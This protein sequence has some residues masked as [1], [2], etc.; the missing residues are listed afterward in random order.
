VGFASYK[1]RVTTLPAEVLAAYPGLSVEPGPYGTGLINVTR[2]GRLGDADVVVQRVHP[3]FAGTVHDDIEAV[4]AHVASKG[5]ATPRLVRAK[6]GALFAADAEGRPWRVLT[7]VDGTS[8]DRVSGPDHATRAGELLGRFHAAVDDLDHAYVHVRPGVHDLGY[9]LEGLT[10]ALSEHGSHRLYDRA[11]ELAEAIIA[12]QGELAPLDVSRHRH[13]HGD[14]KVSN[15]LF[16]RDGKGV[17]LVDLDTLARMPWPF[18]IG[19]ALRSWCNPHGEDREEPQVDEGIFEAA[20]RGFAR[21]T[22]GGLSLDANE[23]EL[24]PRGVFTIA[25]EL[26]IRFLTDALEEKYFGWNSDRYASR[27]DH[28]LARARG[29]WALAKSVRGAMR[30]LEVTARVALHD[31]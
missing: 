25:T 30:R 22:A 26:S 2:K 21:G 28:N 15:L 27:G 29:Q 4:T 1:E 31:R 3:A 8:T 23:I 24:V 13:A 18:E 20:L 9:R 19:D 6:D 10:R 17:A 12:A 7:F 14:L 5:L 11:S 16:D